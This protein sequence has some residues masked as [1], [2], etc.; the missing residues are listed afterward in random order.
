MK[1]TKEIIERIEGEATLELEWENEQVSFAK[2]KFFNYRGIEEILKKRPLLDA[3]AL[4]HRSRRKLGCW[5]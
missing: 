3:L 5:R 1:I 2:I 4:T